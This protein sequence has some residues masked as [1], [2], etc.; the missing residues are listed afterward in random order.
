MYTEVKL[1]MENFNKVRTR[2]NTFQVKLS[3]KH[4]SGGVLFL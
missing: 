1:E 4:T 2:I 3:I